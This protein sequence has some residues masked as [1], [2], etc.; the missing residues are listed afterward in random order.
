MVLSKVPWIYGILR[1]QEEYTQKI[2]I[3]Q[4]NMDIDSSPFIDYI[5]SFKT[6][7]MCFFPQARHMFY[8]R[9]VPQSMMSDTPRP[10]RVIGRSKD[11]PESQ[12]TRLL[13]PVDVNSW[14]VDVVIGVVVKELYRLIDVNSFVSDTIPMDPKTSLEVKVLEVLKYPK[15]YPKHFLR[16]YVDPCKVAAHTFSDYKL[17]YNLYIDFYYLLL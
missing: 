1:S 4:S 17:V 5:P 12:L 15:L 2:T 10:K 9:R 7:F 6:S 8:Y 16:R 13:I 11:Q 14:L 3:L